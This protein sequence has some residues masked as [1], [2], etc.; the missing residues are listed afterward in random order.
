MVVCL[1]R[2]TIEYYTPMV[3]HRGKIY[4]CKVFHARWI[5]LSTSL[6]ISPESHTMRVG[7]GV[8]S[9]SKFISHGKPY[10]MRFL[11]YFTLKVML[12]MLNILHKVKDHENHVRWIYLTTVLYMEESQK[13]TRNTSSMKIS[14]T[15]CLFIVSMVIN[16]CTILA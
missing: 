5:F 7:F 3:P 10:K 6:R 11:T 4:I 16:T 13:Y 9:I 15:E 1:Y 8:A 12:I 14:H 2:F